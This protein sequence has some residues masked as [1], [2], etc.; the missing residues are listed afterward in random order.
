MA[1]NILQF[2]L[3]SRRAELLLREATESSGSLINVI[4][5][6]P[7]QV[8]YERV[9]N[10]QIIQCLRS[11]EVVESPHRDKGGNWHCTSYRLC[12]GSHVYVKTVLVLN[13]DQSLS[14]VY[15]V[16][17]DNRMHL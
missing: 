5:Y 3:A 7:D 16:E 15:V 11:G 2:G 1:E 17:V 14:C 4:P 10:N 6:T 13:S 12:G 8:W 9:T